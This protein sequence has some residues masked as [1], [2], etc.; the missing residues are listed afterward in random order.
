MKVQPTHLVRLSCREQDLVDQAPPVLRHPNKRI[1]YE[2][3]CPPKTAWDGT[4]AFSRWPAVPLPERLSQDGTLTITGVPG[5]FDYE[6]ATGEEQAVEWHLNFAD[7]DLFF[8]YG[9]RLFAQD[10]MQVAEHPALASLREWLIARDVRCS[11]MEQGE[12][13]PVLV[14]GAPRRCRVAIDRNEQEGRPFGLYGNAFSSASPT[15]VERGTTRIDPPSITNLIAIAAPSHGSGP[16]R[17]EEIERVLVTA[18]TGFRAAVVE[19]R[20]PLARN[21]PVVVHTGFWGCGA[22]GGDRVLMTLLQMLAAAAAGVDQI[23]F[24]TGDPSGDA[25]FAE[26]RRRH[27]E[28]L[29]DAGAGGTNDLI[30]RIEKHGFR[31]GRSDGN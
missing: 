7:P 18:F 28:L 4:L 2:I 10:E 21:G 14:A 15:T 13:T 19:S 23:V 9:T 30:R 26:A 31:W 3:A 5:F 25:P 22:F 27:D 6:P 17:A 20:G 29:A 1:V 11:T 16:Y 8:G 12:P 24:H